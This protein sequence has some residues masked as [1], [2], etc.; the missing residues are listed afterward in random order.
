M[1]C[2][3]KLAWAEQAGLVSLALPTPGLPALA[4]RCASSAAE[5]T[6]LPLQFPNAEYDQVGPVGFVFTG[7]LRG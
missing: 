3:G 7:G 1:S 6:K 5:T 4:H 2:W